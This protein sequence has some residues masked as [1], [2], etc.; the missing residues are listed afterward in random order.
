MFL[1]HL[2]ILQAVLLANT[3]PSKLYI[4]LHCFVNITHKLELIAHGQTRGRTAWGKIQYLFISV[5]LSFTIC[6]MFHPLHGHSY[7][8]DQLYFQKT[9]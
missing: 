8:N 1:T 5:S 6:Y 4:A 7:N 2:H 3:S 9:Y